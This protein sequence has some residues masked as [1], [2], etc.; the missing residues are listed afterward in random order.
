MFKKLSYLK[1]RIK[2]KNAISVSLPSDIY[3]YIMIYKKNYY[4]P[5]DDLI[6]DSLFHEEI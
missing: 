1:L 3:L 6:H 2:Q 5:I 4:S